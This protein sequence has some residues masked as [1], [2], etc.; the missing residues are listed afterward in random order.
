[1]PNEGDD[2]GT[3]DE[4]TRELGVDIGS[5]DSALESHEYPT[6]V[7]E[8]IEEFGDHEIELPGGETT[9]EEVLDTQS[10]EEFESAD[11]VKQRILNDVGAEAVGREGYSDRGGSDEGESGGDPQS[12]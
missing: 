12:L 11:G 8:L 10:G 4:D 9:V 2:D 3:G 5:L 7:D 6:T 1:M